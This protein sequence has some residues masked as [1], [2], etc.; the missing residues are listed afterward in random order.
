M[1]TEPRKISCQ[2]SGFA[3]LYEASARWCLRR[4]DQF[5]HRTEFD[6][7][8][9]PDL[10]VG[11][12]IGGGRQSGN[13]AQ[14]ITRKNR[15][16]GDGG[17]GPLMG[18][19][20]R[21]QRRNDFGGG[22]LFVRQIRRAFEEFADHHHARP[23]TLGRAKIRQQPVLQRGFLF[24]KDDRLGLFQRH[25]K[26]TVLLHFAPGG[27]PPFPPVVTDDIGHERLLDLVRR[28]PAAVAVQHQLDQIQMP[29][30]HLA[31]PIQIHRLACQD[32]V[33]GNRF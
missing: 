25:D 21:V 18:D 4:G 8:L 9:R 28:R 23:Q 3:V 15:F 19:N 13:G 10:R 30:G 5:Q 1:L 24:L 31:Q 17:L 2:R 33:L 14:F 6:V 22:R 29:G 7:V 26:M 32:M 20:V 16:E 11:D 12:F 27:F